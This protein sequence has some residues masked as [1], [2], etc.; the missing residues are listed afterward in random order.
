MT[1]KNQRSTVE[2][3]RST[4]KEEAEYDKEKTEVNK[5]YDK[6]IASLRSTKYSSMSDG[7]KNLVAKESSKNLSNYMLHLSV[8][9]PFMLPIG[10]GMIRFR[11]TCE[12]TK[13]LS[14][15]IGLLSKD[16]VRKILFEVCT[17]VV[18]TKVKGDRSKSVLFDGCMLA[19]QLQKMAE[20][21]RSQKTIG[22]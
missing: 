9:C 20:K 4:K 10:I 12:E 15:E 16:K 21:E 1:K 18:P 6:Y 8:M 13:E 19:N 2:K 7:G 17:E 14:K 3:R 22:L 11:D 5:E